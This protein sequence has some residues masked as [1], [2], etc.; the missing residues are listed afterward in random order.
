MKFIFVSFFYNNDMFLDYFYNLFYKNINKPI[1]YND[2]G[3]YA[4]AHQSSSRFWHGSRVSCV[5]WDRN[6]HLNWRYQRS[7][8][9]LL[10]IPKVPSCTIAKFWRSLEHNDNPHPSYWRYQRP[11]NVQYLFLRT[12]IIYLS[13]YFSK[14]KNDLK[15]IFIFVS[16]LFL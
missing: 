4:S 2:V 12:K 14:F 6:P 11:H 7:T 8:L 5:V 15:G 13:F 9:K 1:K 16:S 10:K 3:R